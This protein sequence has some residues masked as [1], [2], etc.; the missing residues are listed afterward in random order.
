MD[1][2]VLHRPVNG[3]IDDGGKRAGIAELIAHSCPEH[4]PGLTALEV[5]RRHGVAVEQQGTAAPDILE[6]RPVAAILLLNVED[7]GD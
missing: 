2:I 3:R 7:D 4:Q 1:E 5:D 6:H